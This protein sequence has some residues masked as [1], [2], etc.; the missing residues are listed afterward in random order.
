MFAWWQRLLFGTDASLSW[1][2]VGHAAPGEEVTIELHGLADPIDVS[3]NCV[4]VALHP[5]LIGI[6]LAN[7]ALP[8]QAEQ[9]PC[10]CLSANDSPAVPS[11]DVSDCA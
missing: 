1:E 11:S 5:C 9:L 3:R 4:P 6:A 7:S 10:T 8:A 2:G